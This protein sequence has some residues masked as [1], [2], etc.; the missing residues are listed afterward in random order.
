MG[1]EIRHITTDQF[2]AWQDVLAL[3]FG[4][5]Y[6]EGD[7]E[8][9]RDRAEFGRYLAAWDGDELVG[10][11]GSL[12]F[13]MQVP[14]GASVPTGG[15]TAASVKQTH[16][17]Q[18]IF[19]SLMGAA[20]DDVRDREEPLA[21]LLASESL[22]YPRYGFGTATESTTLTVERSHARLGPAPSEGGRIR[23]IDLDEAKQVVPR[24][25][26]AAT[27]GI[28]G[29][30]TRTEGDWAIYFNDPEHWRDGATAV[31]Y[32]VFERDGVAAG[33][34]RYRTKEKWEEA[35]PNSE[36]I[37]SDLQATDPGA[38]RELYRFC[39]EHDLIGTIRVRSRR[40]REPI[41]HLMV[42]PRRVG[43]RPGDMIWLRLM[44][45][46]AALAAR[47]YASEDRIVIGVVDPFRPE[48][49]GAY[50]L[51]G[52]PDGAECSRTDREPELTL[53][54]ADLGSAYLGDSRLPAL[55]WL[56]RAEGDP[57]VVLR[58]H[59]MFQGHQDPWCTVFF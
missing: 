8:I 48:N 41:L 36:M 37:V 26:A 7:R 1:I 29:T 28:P 11:N 5:E 51:T 13:E 35:H 16:R 42:E 53:T 20:L 4:F 43:R 6:R 34:V 25:Y 46:P 57:D 55:G 22:I 40:V 31:R 33:F 17:R 59:R 10:T 27:A 15:V 50:L 47:R 19:T 12:T 32:A 18:G 30:I 49:D 2:E 45:V 21:A 3:T 38:Y 24:L 9:W 58:A 52:G 56:G 14:G 23:L 54:M 44:D 39:F